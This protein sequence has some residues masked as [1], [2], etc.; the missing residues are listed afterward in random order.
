MSVLRHF[1]YALSFFSFAAFCG[2]AGA[3]SPPGQ[4][5][6]SQ[7]TAARAGAPT[8]TGLT[9]GTFPVGAVHGKTRAELGHAQAVGGGWISSSAKNAKLLYLASLGT[10]SIGIY[11]QK[12]ANQSPMGTI[13]DG[14]NYPCCMTV[15]DAGNLYVTNE[16]A[17]NVSVYPP[18]Q[19][20]PSTVYTTDLSTACDVAVAHDGTIYISNFN[21]IVNGWVAVY[22]QGDTSKEYRLSDFGGG[23]PLA[24]AL[25]AKENL[26]V[27]YDLNGNG[28]S[29]VNEY[30]P[31]A[32][33]G[34]N[35][36]LNFKFGAGIALDKHGD[37]VVVQQVEPSEILVFPP[38]A[39]QPS[40]TITEPGGDQAFAIALDKRSNTL[41]AAD[42]DQN[43]VD[44]FTYPAGVLRYSVA[45]G[46]DNP[47]GIAVSPP[48]RQR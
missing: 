30:A 21:G 47:S 28:S 24:L 7:L 18:G 19:T 46:F 29:A 36:N 14:L 38:G 26:F 23:A 27:M 44:D 35:L 11:S 20:S 3:A 32:T 33:V 40:Q 6:T 25:D 16:G 13:T 48:Q 8:L 37:V 22:P 31:G 45:G 42:D 9:G 10:N 41:F 43:V 1:S 4:A 2:C 17:N 12:G 39:T 15:D 5:M 34:T